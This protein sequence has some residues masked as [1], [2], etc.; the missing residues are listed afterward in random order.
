MSA[1]AIPLGRMILRAEREALAQ[2]P[3][4]DLM[5]LEFWRTAGPSVRAVSLQWAVGMFALSFLAGILTYV[6]VLALVRRMRASRPRPAITGPAGPPPAGP[7]PA[8]P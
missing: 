7:P 3:W 8:A 2:L 4:K 1:V 6:I 5:K